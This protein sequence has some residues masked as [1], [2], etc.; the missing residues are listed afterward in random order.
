MTMSPVRSFRG[1]TCKI[2]QI[3]CVGSFL[4]STAYDRLVS[5][6]LTS[7]VLRTKV[8]L[9]ACHVFIVM[10]EG[11][12]NVHVAISLDTSCCFVYPWCLEFPL[13]LHHHHHIFSYPN[14]LIRI[15]FISVIL[16]KQTTY[17]PTSIPFLQNCT[18]LVPAHVLYRQVFGGRRIPLVEFVFIIGEQAP[19]DFHQKSQGSSKDE[20]WRRREG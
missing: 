16:I 11:L 13:L 9:F 5:L 14:V 12:H 2:N 20:W 4:F 10:D 3:I 1:H 18:Y 8:L 17:T 15:C 19:W 6:F 7:K